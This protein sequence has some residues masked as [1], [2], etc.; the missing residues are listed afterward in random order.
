[1]RARMALVFLLAATVVLTAT[2]SAE[3]TSKRPVLSVSP[4]HPVIDDGITVHINPRRPLPAGDVFRVVVTALDGQI[5]NGFS[6]LAVVNTRS[7]SVFV[8]PERPARRERV[9]AGPSV[10]VCLRGPQGRSRERIRQESRIR[11]LPV[12]RL[13]V[14]A[15]KMNARMLR[16]G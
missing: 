11:L 2:V 1:M 12:L 13:A 3:A 7:R 10:R 6:H 9:A 8:T 15:Q 4:S 16:S 14:G 5:D